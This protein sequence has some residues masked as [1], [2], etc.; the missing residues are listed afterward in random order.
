MCLEIGLLGDHFFFWGC[1]EHFLE[2]YLL[3]SKAT[4]G[5]KFAFFVALLAASSHVGLEDF[6]EMTKRYAQGITPSPV[7]AAATDDDDDEDHVVVKN[8]DEL[9]LHQKVKNFSI[10]LTVLRICCS[11]KSEVNKKKIFFEQALATARR[12]TPQVSS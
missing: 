3:K 12:N 6:V 9:P 11:L 7:M 10:T 1:S 4:V 5:E 8:P 2:N